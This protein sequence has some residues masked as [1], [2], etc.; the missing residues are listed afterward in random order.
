MGTPMQRSRSLAI[1]IL[2]VVAVCA[3]NPRAR[4]TQ[5]D[6]VL[7]IAHALAVATTGGTLVQ[8]DA[9]FPADDMLQQ[10]VPVQVVVRD[11]A[12]GGSHYARVVLGG[13]A[14]SGVDPALTDGLEPE[15]VPALLASGT[16]LAGARVLYVAPG[17]I[18]FV[19]PSDFPVALAEVQIFLVFEG[20]PLLS[21]PAPL[22]LDGATP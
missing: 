4:A 21:N 20:D 22:G 5:T 6:P 9:I 14:V 19:L 2:A 18:E 1:A 12:S 13:T 17:R 15:D 10:Q 7:E 8:L 16:P 3:P 11:L